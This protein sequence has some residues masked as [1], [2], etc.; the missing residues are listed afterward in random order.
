M[1]TQGMVKYK[2]K[3]EAGWDCGKISEEALGLKKRRLEGA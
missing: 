3:R 2:W 1:V